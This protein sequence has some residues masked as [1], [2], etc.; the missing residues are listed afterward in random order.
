[1]TKHHT[2]LTERQLAEL[3][4]RYAAGEPFSAIAA[5]YGVTAPTVGNWLRGR[6][7]PRAYARHSKGKEPADPKYVA[8]LSQRVADGASV[9]EVARQFGVTPQAVS[10]I[11]ARRAEPVRVI[12]AR[13]KK[14]NAT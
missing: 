8:T 12:R 13:T 4:R 5:D 14:G 10:F 7:T 3:A 1:M 6:V 9:C 11:L 2:R